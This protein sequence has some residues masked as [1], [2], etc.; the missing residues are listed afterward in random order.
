MVTSDVTCRLQWLHWRLRE[1]VLHKVGA[2]AEETVDIEQILQFSTTKWHY[3]IDE[4]NVWFVLRLKQLMK[5]IE[6]WCVTFMVVMMDSW[7]VIFYIHSRWSLSV[8]SLMLPINVITSL[9]LCCISERFSG[10][11]THYLCLC[12]VQM[13]NVVATRSVVTLYKK[14]VS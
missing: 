6:E 14:K 4:S 5:E 3:P 12:M 2:Q 7:I 11:C 13:L 1:T 8:Q 9:L 10:V